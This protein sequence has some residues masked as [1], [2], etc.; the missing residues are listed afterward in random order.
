MK[1]I[2]Y[3]LFIVSL[4]LFLTG[5]P[6]PPKSG[7]MNPQATNYNS[8]ATVADNCSC[9]FDGINSSCGILHPTSI[10]IPPIQQETEEWCWLA[11]GQMI[12]TYYGLP[13]VNGAGDYQCGIVGAVGYSMN[14]ACDEC[15]INCGNCVRPAGSSEMVSYMLT[16]YPKIAC[17]D[18]FTSNKTLN[19]S[20]VANYLSPGFLINE[21]NNYRPVIAGINPGSQFVLPGNSQHV[22]LIKGYY[23]DINNNLILIV[24]DPYPYW[25]K[26][27]DVYASN[28]G[29]NNGDLSYQIAYTNFVN[30]L[31]W[32]TSYYNIGW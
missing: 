11:V 18:L 32:N 1:K 6:D 19:N 31:L 27:V 30:G 20:F 23:Y 13:T 8:S 24:N 28:G 17:R 4:E 25:T 5:C 15:N 7:C 29:I 16:V 9:K 10:I 12:F 26:G 21:L 3:I 2:V 14:G 22:S